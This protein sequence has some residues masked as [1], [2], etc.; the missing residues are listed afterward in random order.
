VDTTATI[1]EKTPDGDSLRLVF[2]LGGE[3]DEGSVL[4]CLIT[5]GYIALDGTSLTLTSVNDDERTFGV[6]LITHTQEKITLSKKPVGSKV[7]VEADMVAKYV[8]KS[9]AAVVNGSEWEAK[10]Q[11]IVEKTLQRV[12][13][14]KLSLQ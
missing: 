8:Q 12:A 1:I 6:M 7:N 3:S 2:Q 4:P 13:G 5:K 14:D 11:R 9:I 10:T